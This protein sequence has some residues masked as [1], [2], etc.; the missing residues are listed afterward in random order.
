MTL[1]EPIGRILP[2]WSDPDVLVKF[3]KDNGGK[4]VLRKAKNQMTLR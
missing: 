1:D 3:D 4:P 2:E